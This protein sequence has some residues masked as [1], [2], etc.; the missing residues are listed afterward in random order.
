MAGVVEARVG[1]NSSFFDPQ[2]I[3]ELTENLWN[4]RFTAVTRSACDV[5]QRIRLET[6]TTLLIFSYLTCA[7]G[8]AWALIVGG[9][10]NAPVTDPGWPNGA[11]D[12]FNQ[13]A[14]VASWIGPPFGGGHWHGEYRGDTT[15]FNEALKLFAK[16]DAK[17]KRL[18]VYEGVGHSFWLNPNREPAKDKEAEIDWNFA[19]W[20]KKS[21]EFQRKLPV[22]LRPGSLG[23]AED[24]PP[25]EL[26]VYT[27]GNI[28]WAEVFVPN[29]VTV[30]DQRLEAHGYKNEDGAVFEGVITDFQSKKPLL[31][32]IELQLIERQPKKNDHYKTARVVVCDVSGHWTLKHV[33]TGL[34]R[35]VASNDGYV[36]RVLGT[37][38]IEKQACWQNY[39]G[40]LSPAVRVSG[41]AVDESETP[42]PDVRVRL[43]EI[44]CNDTLYELTREC[45]ST[46]D[47]EGRFHFDQLPIGS[48]RLRVH[49]SGYCQANPHSTIALP[50]ENI[51]VKMP[52]PA[53]LRVKVDC[54]NTT[55]AQTYF[56][57]LAPDGGSKASLGQRRKMVDNN[58]MVN[59][60]DV[61][62]GRYV[63]A[64]YPNPAC[65]QP[66]TNLVTVDLIG[67]MTED[68][69]LV[70]K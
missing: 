19:V 2:V 70:S 34:H 35:L 46:T 24:G 33:P 12:V 25:I 61:P 49:K 64:G 28:R 8:P 1:S 51:D 53:Q 43:D 55:R 54:A 60:A 63:V 44:E 50:A 14:R 68:I 22:G 13:P 7:V 11:S 41:R 37:M 65:D 26:S 59:F 45:V 27:G 31:A 5:G 3:I 23:D 40:E 69:T 30:I 4:W 57:K 10:G 39:D 9:Q 21:W 17:S 38:Q 29:D 15:T 48:A 42:L 18:N 62:P 67:G 32:Q 47:A 56:I 58:E 66:D 36:P 20:E 52:R 16:I 6:L